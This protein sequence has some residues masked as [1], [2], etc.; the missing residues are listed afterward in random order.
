MSTSIIDMHIGNKFEKNDRIDPYSNKCTDGIRLTIIDING[1]KNQYNRHIEPLNGKP[2]IFFFRTI[3]MQMTE[4]HFHT[5][6]EENK[7]IHEYDKKDL[8]KRKR[9]RI[10]RVTRGQSVEENKPKANLLDLEEIE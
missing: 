8:Q 1:W 6:C 10:H 3:C 2:L 7:E 9:R 4:S 5:E